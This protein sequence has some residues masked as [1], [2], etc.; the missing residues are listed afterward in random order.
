MQARLG[1]EGTCWWA[2]PTLAP[3]CTPRVPPVHPCAACP[4][5]TRVFTGLRL[6]AVL[7][8]GVMAASLFPCKTSWGLALRLE[9]GAGVTLVIPSSHRMPPAQH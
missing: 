8:P 3:T 4:R 9:A 5:L 6:G 1:G 7:S 2:G